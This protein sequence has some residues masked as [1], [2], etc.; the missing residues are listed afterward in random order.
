MN[1]GTSIL[2]GTPAGR[3]RFRGGNA[4]PDANTV[5]GVFGNQSR[6]GG[7]FSGVGEYFTSESTAQ[8]IGEYFSA[9]ARARGLGAI[10]NS[11]PWGEYSDD[12]KSLQATLN[13]MLK[14]QGLCQIS[15]DGKL[16]PATCGAA[17]A[18]NPE[19]VPST[20]QGFTTPTKCAPGTPA[21]SPGPAPAPPPTTPAAPLP[22]APGGSMFA[23]KGLLIAGV[24]AVGVGAFLLARKKRRRR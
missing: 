4:A 9:D 6:G 13:S 19:W 16:G 20:C 18:M 10:Q 1:Y 14:S 2:L 24:A 23:G 7:I 5:G 12:T 17:K 15:T 21:P 22:S 3:S 8:G 11:H